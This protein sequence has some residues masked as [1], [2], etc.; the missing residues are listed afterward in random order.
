[1]MLN[2]DICLA[3]L[4]NSEHDACVDQKVAQGMTLSRANGQCKGLQRKGEFLNAANVHCCAWTNTRAVFNTGV[5]RRGQTSEYCGVQIT[6]PGSF[7][8]ARE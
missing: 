8:L 5:L 3:Y 7:E 2:S 1:M 4:H 6:E